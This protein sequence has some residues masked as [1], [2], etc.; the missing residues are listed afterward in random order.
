MRREVKSALQERINDKN[1]K[2]WRGKREVPDFVL[3]H[4]KKSFGAGPKRVSTTVIHIQCKREDAP[5]LKGMVMQYA[6]RMP[7][8]FV[9]A[10]YH[11]NRSPARML[12]ILNSHNRWVNRKRKIAIVG[13]TEELMESRMGVASD[14]CTVKEYLRDILKL[15][16]IETTSRTSD[17]GK[18]VLIT[19]SEILEQTRGELD[20]VVDRISEKYGENDNMMLE[21]IGRPRRTNRSIA[22]QCYKNGLDHLDKV[23]PSNESGDFPSIP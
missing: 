6:K 11:L 23:M 19:E 13:M 14:Q 8:P 22:A 18:W 21:E 2:R 3:Y 17:L 10:G 5:E 16:Q 4:D 20:E 15:T 9:P 1:E 12:E 7:A